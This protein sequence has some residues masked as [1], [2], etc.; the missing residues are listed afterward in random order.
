M[1]AIYL[2]LFG[3]YPA[4]SMVAHWSTSVLFGQQMSCIWP[5]RCWIKDAFEL[6]TD[7]LEDRPVLYTP[8]KYALTQKTK[9]NNLIYQ[10]SHHFLKRERSSLKLT[11]QWSLSGSKGSW[12]WDPS[13]ID[14]ARTLLLSSTRWR[15]LHQ[16]KR[17][18]LRYKECN[19]FFQNGQVNHFFH[20]R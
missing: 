20:G 3:Y 7:N 19:Q 12:L 10:I 4:V 2:Q 8:K 15:T 13:Y 16:C 18:T 11:C 6:Y 1:I 9:N 17:K 14:H 5:G